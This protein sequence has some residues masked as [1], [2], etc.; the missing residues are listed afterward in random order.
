MKL[1]GGRFSGK[2]DPAA[3]K[4]NASIEF[5]QRLARQDIRGS[6]AWAAALEKVGVLSSAECAQICAGLE[7]IQEEFA[8]GRFIIQESDEDIH[9]AVERR[10]AEIIGPV[11]GRL[12]TGRS[13]NDQVATDL[14]FWLLEYL[15]Q[16]DR[17]LVGLQT[18]LVARA[19][20]DMGV[21][22]PGYT[23]LQPAQPVLL[24]HWWLSYFWPL[25][26]DRER[27]AA[28]GVAPPCSRWAPAPWR[29]HL[30]ASTASPWQPTWA[31]P[32]PPPTA[33]TPSRTEILSPSSC[34][35]PRWLACT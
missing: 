5:D 1:W 9:T 7:A 29:E 21:I 15:P 31:L 32:G 2:L 17:E 13:R 22:M 12:H 4:L 24:S 28:T 10:L 30:I 27:L 14:R 35:A 3:W 18:A 16:L 8:N 19:E 23:H 20:A 34:F 33:S 25:Q 11:A 26:R 6:Q